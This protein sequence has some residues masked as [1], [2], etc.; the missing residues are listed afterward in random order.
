MQVATADGTLVP[1]AGPITIQDLLRH[2][3][4]IVYG[5]NTPNEKVKAAYTEHKLDWANQTPAEQ[6]ERLAKVPLANHPGTAF[7]YSL[8]TDIL[9]RV[10][11]KV[12]GMTLGAFLG[13]RLFTPLKMK[14]TAFMVPQGKLTRLAQPWAVDEAT[15][16]PIKL[17]DVT[18]AP[19]NDAGGAG[20]AGTAADYV[21]FCQM[22][23]NG[24]KLDGV[25]I[26]GK[27]TVA[28]M[29]SDHL[30]TI[31]AVGPT[32][33]AG[34][35]FGLGFAVRKGGGVNSTIGSAGEY[36]W[37]G[38]GGTGFWIDPKEQ[39]IAIVMT[40]TVPGPAQRM[41]RALFRHAVYQAIT[42]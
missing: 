6:I 30:D 38:A 31:K 29:T 4:G 2:T 41:D 36:N 3:S 42:D 8:S 14:D 13:E 35:G 15:G 27:A 24:G 9:G 25:R 5:N 19:K 12:S 37:G 21:R 40:Q 16:Q 22:L 23:L 20:T 32:L 17:V 11:E 39:L 1:A 28:Y 33:Q 18:V 7:E 26:L 34:Y 10:V